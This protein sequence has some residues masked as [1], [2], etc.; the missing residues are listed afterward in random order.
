MVSNDNGSTPY[1]V[2]TQEEM[3]VNIEARDSIGLPVADLGDPDKF[4]ELKQL[5]SLIKQEQGHCVYKKFMVNF[6]A[7]AINVAMNVLRKIVL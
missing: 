6:G 7:L 3:E 4:S 1:A 5:R 2:N